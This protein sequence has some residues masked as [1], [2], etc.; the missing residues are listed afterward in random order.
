[1]N[2]LICEI[3]TTNITGQFFSIFSPSEMSKRNK[4]FQT[5]WNH[6][7]NEF[8]L[9]D[10]TARTFAKKALYEF[11]SSGSEAV[12]RTSVLCNDETAVN[13]DS[14]SKFRTIEGICNNLD[15]PFLGAFDSKFIR[16]VEVEPYDALSIIISDPDIGT[17]LFFCYY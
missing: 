3:D 17:L 12:T 1:M 6:L 13:C 15:K 10:A 9:D 16:E 11:R 5:I 4:I 7:K 8:D 2:A 14:I